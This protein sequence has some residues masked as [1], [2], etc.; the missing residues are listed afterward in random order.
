MTPEPQRSATIEYYDTTAAAYFQ[1]T[2]G[3]DMASTRERLT[4]ELSQGA[5]IL[6]AGCGSGRDSKAF[7]DAGF[8]VTAFDASAP[9]AALAS[10]HIGQ[11]VLVRRFQELDLGQTFDGIYA[12]A[13]L[14]HLDNEE[15]AQAFL[16]LFAHLRPHGRMLTLFKLG[17]GLRTDTATGRVFNDMTADR[18]QGFVE[19]ACGRMLATYIDKDRMGRGNDWIAGISAHA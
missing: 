5:H 17:A 1:Q 12:S 11:P 9:L 18:L 19:R 3:I 13:S 2:L 15:L 7:K 14:L 4:K 6:D 8:K 16:T 10:G